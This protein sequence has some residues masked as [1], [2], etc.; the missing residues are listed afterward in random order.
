MLSGEK[1]RCCDLRN[2]YWANI[3]GVSPAARRPAGWRGWDACSLLLLAGKGR[4]YAGI[5]GAPVLQTEAAFIPFD[6]PA[7]CSKPSG[8]ARSAL[9]VFSIALFLRLSHRH[10][11]ALP[12]RF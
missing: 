6:V 1:E 8:F 10:I 5:L 7:D 4:G 2:C 12:R 3:G 9:V 11:R